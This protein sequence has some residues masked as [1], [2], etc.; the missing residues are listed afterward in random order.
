MSHIFPVFLCVFSKPFFGSSNVKLYMMCSCGIK[1]ILFTSAVIKVPAVAGQGP[2]KKAA[3]Q[4]A[5][6]AAL[7]ILN[8]DSE[9]G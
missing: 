5:A 4:Q 6:E 1:Y 2:S 9:S 3:K 7:K 8:I